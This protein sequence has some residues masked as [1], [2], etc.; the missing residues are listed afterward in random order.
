M[1]IYRGKSNSHVLYL[2]QI[3]KGI[4]DSL[5]LKRSILT[6]DKTESLRHTHTQHTEA[7]FLTKI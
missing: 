2:K 3:N 5:H 6:L 4:W 7:V 1:I